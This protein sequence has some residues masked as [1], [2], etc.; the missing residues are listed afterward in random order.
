MIDIS[1][2]PYI[3]EIGSESE[4]SFFVLFNW[5]GAMYLIN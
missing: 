3:N 5:K 1:Y 2:A 4:A